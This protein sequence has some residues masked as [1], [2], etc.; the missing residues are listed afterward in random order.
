MWAVVAWWPRCSDV[1]IL[2]TVPPISGPLPPPPLPPQWRPCYPAAQHPPVMGNFNQSQSWADCLQTMGLSSVSCYTF[3]LCF[4][5][6]TD[7]L[8][9]SRVPYLLCYLIAV[10]STLYLHYIMLVSVWFCENAAK[11]WQFRDVSMDKILGI[12]C[13]VFSH[14]SLRLRVSVPES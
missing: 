4:V 7:W 2:A 9:V 11:E 8:F 3:P 10:I 14:I 5:I 1:L 13:K 12:Q 6:S